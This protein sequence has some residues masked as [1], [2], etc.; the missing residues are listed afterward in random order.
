MARKSSQSF[1]APRGEDGKFIPRSQWSKKTQKEF[2]RLQRQGAFRGPKKNPIVR[3]SSGRRRGKNIWIPPHDKNGRFLPMAQWSA[4]DKKAYRKAL[5]DGLVPGSLVPRGHA[6]RFSG[7]GAA[8]LG[9]SR[10]NRKAGREDEWFE[11]D[12][13]YDLKRGI[14]RLEHRL[15]D[16][17][18]EMERVGSRGRARALVDRCDDGGCQVPSG[19]TRTH[20][21]QEFESPYVTDP[22]VEDAEWSET[23]CSDPCQSEILSE[24]KK[25]G[26]VCRDSIERLEEHR[27]L[28]KNRS[29]V[30]NSSAQL[31]MY[32][33]PRT[34]GQHFDE[35]LGY[36]KAHPVVAIAGLGA[37]ALIGFA[38]YKMVRTILSNVVAG[39]SI[40]QGVMSFP[41]ST[42][43]LITQDDALWLIRAIW[44]EV[45][46]SNERWETSAVQRGAAAVLWALA[47]NYMTV[48]RKR[49]LYPTF[50]QYIQAYCQPINPIWSS[51]G[52][53]GC[54]R[55]PGA[56][57]ADRLAFRQALRSKPWA[58]F[59]PGAQALVTAFVAGTLSN[60]IGR[61][62]DWAA[63]GEG[64]TT[65]DAVNIAGN[66]FIT[67]P[68]ARSRTAAV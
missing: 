28:S 6:G 48:G 9:R 39:A 12:D 44:G 67:D 30:K 17:T 19:R 65:I 45:N 61:R 33:R 60:P 8:G 24:V 37:L 43:Y 54:Q 23:S 56:C 50:G 46:R 7:D 41:G 15:E 68:D 53:S 32:N 11:S 29:L 5:K 59:P 25:I 1:V 13:L 51:A 55:N 63:A 4:V 49:E 64:R 27:G 40:R 62:T 34:L 31:M 20:V 57:T 35:V 10:G 3:S 14:R 26:G 18:D 66:V 58:Q 22:D 21:N 42:Q 16:L 52:A 36:L 38:L 2:D 47:N